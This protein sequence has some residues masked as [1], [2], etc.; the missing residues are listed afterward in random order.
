[1]GADAVVEGHQPQERAGET[2][3]IGE[4]DVCFHVPVSVDAGLKE[5]AETR[6]PSYETTSLPRKENSGF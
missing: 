5:N 3:A 1:L 6:W 4:A 2:Q